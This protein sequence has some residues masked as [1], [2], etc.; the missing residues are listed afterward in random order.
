VVRDQ[1][2][3]DAGMIDPQEGTVAE[4]RPKAPRP[5]RRSNS[6]PDPAKGQHGAKPSGDDTAYRHRARQRCRL[7]RN[8]RADTAKEKDRVRPARPPIVRFSKD[9]IEQY[10]DLVTPALEISDANQWTRPRRD[11]HHHPDV[12]I[13][14]VLHAPQSMGLQ[15]F[16]DDVDLD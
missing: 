1:Q 6:P 8:H 7:P 9:L 12:E 10:V 14:S 5:P 4:Q 2:P 16:A 11:D 3:F 13:G 15:L